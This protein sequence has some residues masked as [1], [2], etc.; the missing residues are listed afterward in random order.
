AARG[1]EARP[2][3][4]LV[5]R[6]EHREPAEANGP[7]RPHTAATD[8]VAA[9]VASAVLGVEVAPGDAEAALATRAASLTSALSQFETSVVRVAEDR[10]DPETARL[11]DEARGLRQIKDESTVRLANATVAVTSA[12]SYITVSYAASGGLG[13]SLM[14]RIAVVFVITIVF[15]LI[16]IYTLE[17]LS[18][19][20]REERGS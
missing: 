7:R 6:V 19:G 3:S 20:L 14:G 11:L 8:D 10:L 12:E 2:A 16:A 17:W 5:A 13:R 15:G 9:T 4:E 18:A 1:A